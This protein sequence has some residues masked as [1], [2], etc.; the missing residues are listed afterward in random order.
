MVQ[1]FFGRLGWFAL[2][3]ALQVFVFNH[4]HIFGYATPLPYV[5]FLLTLSSATKRWIP[6]LTSFLMGLCIDLFNNTPGVAASS[7]CLT[8]LVAPALLKFFT[9]Q[10]KEDGE[11]TPSVQTMEWKGF[12]RYAAVI[13]IINT[14]VYCL[15]E[16]FTLSN[17]EYLLLTI[18]GSTVLSFL[19]VLGF[20]L[21]RNS[22]KKYA[23]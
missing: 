6:I 19:F 4:V 22:G 7:F 3:L 12:I 21:I 2:L 10:D 16:A 9:P 17:W 14:F 13:V 23:K 8:G 15:V 18:A 11:W 20:E 1:I 5:F